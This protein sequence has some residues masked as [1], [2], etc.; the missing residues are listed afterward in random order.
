[1]NG[2]ASAGGD[3]DARPRQ[4]A[5]KLEPGKAALIV[6]VRKSTPDNVLRRLGNHDGH[7]LQ[8]SLSDADE[9]RRRAAVGD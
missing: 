8:T 6:L 7:V 4:L 9:A 5:A 3:T 2:S 1:M